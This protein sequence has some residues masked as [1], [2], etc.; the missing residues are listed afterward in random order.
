MAES[1]YGLAGWEWDKR[2]LSISTG[3]RR[4]SAVLLRYHMKQWSA[5]FH[6][7]GAAS[8]NNQYFYHYYQ[9]KIDRLNKNI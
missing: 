3:L 6:A 7:A 4:A 2:N 8:V 5:A 9:E 1:G